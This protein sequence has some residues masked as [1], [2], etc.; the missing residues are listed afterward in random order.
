MFQLFHHIQMVAAYRGAL[1]KVTSALK[2]SSVYMVLG[3]IFIFF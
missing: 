3:G 2:T 1:P